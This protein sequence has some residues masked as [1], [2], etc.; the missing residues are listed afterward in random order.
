MGV[1]ATGGGEQRCG[2][3]A[4]AKIMWP[5]WASWALVGVVATSILTIFATFRD[6]F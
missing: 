4:K 2:A 6:I 5:T 3:M 1:R